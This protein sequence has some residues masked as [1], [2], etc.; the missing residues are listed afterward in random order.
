MHVVE[1]GSDLREKADLFRPD[2]D[3]DD[4]NGGQPEARRRGAAIRFVHED[5]MRF[6]FEG[7]LQGGA[8]ADVELNPGRPV[9]KRLFYGADNHPLRPPE[10][11]KSSEP[12]TRV[13]KFGRDLLWSKDLGEE[14]GQIPP[15]QDSRRSRYRQQRSHGEEPLQSNR[16]LLDHACRVSWDGALT[17]GTLKG[18]E[19]N[20]PARSAPVT[21]LILP[22]A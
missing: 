3:A 14:R 10:A 19:V 17:E 4:T 13:G 15:A 6:D 22:C 11:L 21:R 16:I 12:C 7:Q 18:E 5:C 20:G 9:Q 2:Q 8:F 1:N